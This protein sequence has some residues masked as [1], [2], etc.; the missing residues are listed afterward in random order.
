MGR[1][2][3]PKM[4]KVALAVLEAKVEDVI[5]KDAIKEIK[6]PALQRELHEALIE[7]VDRAEKR[8]IHDSPSN[9]IIDVLKQLPIS[10]LEKLQPYLWDYFENPL[11]TQLYNAIYEQLKLIIP[12]SVDKNKLVEVMKN[13]FLY[14][15]EEAILIPEVAKKLVPIAIVKTENHTARTA[16]AV[17]Q[18]VK[19][20]KTKKI[21]SLPVDYDDYLKFLITDLSEWQGG[22]TKI[23]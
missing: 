7:A 20:T 17:E 5:G 2:R 18:L 4:G 21:D 23:V 3:F 22:I 10:S 16:D 19:L 9:D 13:Y 15:R 6:T 14:F 8:L 11:S 1:Q 12:A